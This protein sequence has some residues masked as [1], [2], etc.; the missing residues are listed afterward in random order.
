[1]TIDDLSQIAA[2]RTRLPFTVVYL[3]TEALRSQGWPRLSTKMAA[4]LR[5]SKLMGFDVV[6][7]APV[8][9]EY[10][11]QWM[12]A[13]GE[14]LMA[15]EK[16]QRTLAGHATAA[17]TRIDSPPVPDVVR[18]RLAYQTTVTRLKEEYGILNIPFP[19]VATEVLFD[20]AVKRVPP[21]TVSGKGSVGFQDTVIL[22]AVLSDLDRE[23]VDPFVKT[24][25][26]PQ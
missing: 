24:I 13:F 7:P 1:M 26:W 6:L 17:G 8:E 12:T 20:L 9:V 19:Q 14:A 25:F 11:H 15:H 23:K 10:E 4:L 16:T 3:D 2:S 18:V 22:Q 5:Y 21:F